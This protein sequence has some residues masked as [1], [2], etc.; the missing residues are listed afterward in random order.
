[1][2]RGV[3]SDVPRLVELLQEMQQKS[4]F[5]PDIDVDVPTA[6]G[7]LQ[8]AVQRNGGQHAGGSI[9]LVIE[10]AGQIEA[11]IVGILDRVY[12]IGNRLAANDI[13]LYASDKAT[14][15][16]PRKLIDGYIA[17]AL[18]NKKV[19]KIMLS[20]TDALGVDGDKIERLYEGRGFHRVGAIWER[21]GQ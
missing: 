5:A 13:F 7:L 4:K 19:A 12:H 15:L 10:V 6:R 21:D 17:W 1:M 14:K 20:W 3:H 9:V 2:R 16:A 11:F 18:G 8:T